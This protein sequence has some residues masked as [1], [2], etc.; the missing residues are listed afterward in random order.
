MSGT[1]LISR[2]LVIGCIFL[3]SGRWAC[4]WEGGR[5]KGGGRVIKRPFTVVPVI[6]SSF[7]AASFAVRHTVSNDHL[8]CDSEQ[9]N[10]IRRRHVKV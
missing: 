8:A 6:Y 9:K 7:V 1:G 4:N 10:P 5:G 2:G 3:F